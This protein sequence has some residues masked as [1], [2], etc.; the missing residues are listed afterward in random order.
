MKVMCLPSY[1]P[2]LNPNEV[3]FEKPKLFIGR[4]WYSIKRKTPDQGFDKY[5][6][7]CVDTV[8]G[9]R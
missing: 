3:F 1:S 6:E 9:K 5:L 2:D 7:G 4:H 8:G